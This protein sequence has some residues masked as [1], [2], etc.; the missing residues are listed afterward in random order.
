[1]QKSNTQAI[2]KKMTRNAIK[3]MRLELS[4]EEVHALSEACTSKVLQFPELQEAETVCVYMPTGNEI[5]TSA[6][7]QYCL[8]NGKKVAAPRVEGDTMEF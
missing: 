1:M 6:I 7:I 5:D 2:N 8:D 4:E 3:K